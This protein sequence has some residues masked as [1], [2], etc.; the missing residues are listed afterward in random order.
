MTR[1]SCRDGGAA[2][3][4][5]TRYAALLAPSPRRTGSDLASS[6][7]GSCPWRAAISVVLPCIPARAHRSRA[8]RPG[9]ASSSWSHPPPT[10]SRSR[11]RTSVVT[12][13]SY[14]RRRSSSL[15]RIARPWPRSSGHTA[16][17]LWVAR[18][19]AVRRH[20]LLW[21]RQ[22]PPRCRGQLGLGPGHARDRS[23]SGCPVRLW[24]RSGLE[25]RN[26]RSG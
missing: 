12:G 9:R 21:T 17:G 22:P 11:E 26:G 3:R 16:R 7:I 1:P 14:G 24:T 15:A 6:R 5:L 13:A 19:A 10:E 2:A 4:R 18:L 25:R 8:R 23:G 20:P